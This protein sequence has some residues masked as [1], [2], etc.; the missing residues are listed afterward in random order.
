MKRLVGSPLSLRHPDFIEYVREFYLNLLEMSY[1]Q[2]KMFGH[3]FYCNTTAIRAVTYV[4]EV[5]PEEDLF[6]Q[7]EYETLAWPTREEII[8]TLT[9]G[10]EPVWYQKSTYRFQCGSLC[11]EARF[12]WLFIRGKLL[13]NKSK[14]DV[15]T[16]V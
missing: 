2:M 4:P 8:A 16:T 6:Y 10:Q 9:M 5:S 15:T 3:D 1:G 14:S 13:G 11:G 12:W 7:L